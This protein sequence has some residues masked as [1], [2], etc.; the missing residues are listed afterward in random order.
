MRPKGAMPP[1]FFNFTLDD[2][3]TVHHCSKKGGPLILPISSIKLRQW[4]PAFGLFFGFWLSPAE[5]ELIWLL[6]TSGFCFLS[7][8]CYRLKIQWR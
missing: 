5:F 8:L 6:S 7:Q 4:S 3:D 2:F 1:G